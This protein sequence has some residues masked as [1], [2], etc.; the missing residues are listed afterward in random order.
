[1]TIKNH[2][3][4]YGKQGSVV[5]YSRS[6]LLKELDYDTLTKE[7]LELLKTSPRKQPQ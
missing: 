6:R 7:K 1:V 3:L 5:G 2:Q 4:R